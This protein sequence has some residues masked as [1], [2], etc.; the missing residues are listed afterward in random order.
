MAG[1]IFNLDSIRSLKAC[2]SKGI[3]ATKLSKP[4]GCWKK[5]HEGTFADYVTM[6]P[7]DNIYF[8]IKRKIYGIGVLVDIQGNCKFLNYPEACKPINYK[9]KEKKKDL[10]CDEG[11]QSMKKRWVCIFKSCP[12]FF[13]EGVDMDDVLASNPNAFRMLRAFWKLSMIKCDDEENQAL[14]SVILRCNE[15]KKE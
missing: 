8:F 12:Y 1:Y 9:Y 4:K 10:L 7:K 15:E 5:H 6:R 11:V 3:Y 2:F 14:R 13:K